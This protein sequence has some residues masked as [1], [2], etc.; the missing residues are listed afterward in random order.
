MGMPAN[1]EYA[2]LDEIKQEVNYAKRIFRELKCQII[3]VSAR[4]IEET[5]SEIFL[6]L[7]H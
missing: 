4:A 6:Y 7:R 2:D 3:D 5:S 1:S